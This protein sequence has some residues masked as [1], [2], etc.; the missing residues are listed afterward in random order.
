MNVFLD[1]SSLV[2]LY[3]EETGTEEIQSLF[4]NQVITAIFLSEITKIEFSSAI[5]KKCRNN[6]FSE[7]DARAV[8]NKFES[9]LVRYT[10]VELSGR[11]IEEAQ[12]VM[13]KYGMLGARTLDVIQLSTAILLSKK[14]DLFLTSDILLK[15]FFE[16]ENLST[17]IP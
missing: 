1:T 7:E 6:K 11:V 4:S 15:S 8:L 2:K 17:Q 16:A 5:W 13:A 10:F 9:D 14:A 3:H 12:R